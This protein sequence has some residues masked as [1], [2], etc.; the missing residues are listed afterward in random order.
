MKGIL[1]KVYS[2]STFGGLLFVCLFFV[3]FGGGD[4]GVFGK[5]LENCH[6]C[7]KEANVI[8][9][10][11]LFVLQLKSDIDEMNRQERSMSFW[12]KSIAVAHQIFH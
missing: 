9:L 8:C 12:R 5:G 2:V 7:Q 11:F 1:S 6:R 10:F 3:C 4:G